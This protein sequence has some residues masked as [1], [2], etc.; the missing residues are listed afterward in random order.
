MFPP[1]TTAAS[2]VPSLEEVM[3][4][5]L[6]VAPADVSSVQV[7][8]ESVEVHMFPP[9]TTAASL[10]P[11]LEEVMPSQAFVVARGGPGCSRISGGPYVSVV[12][13]RGELGAVARGG[14]ATP[15]FRSCPRRS[16]CSRISGGPDVSVI[17]NRGEL[18][19]VARGGDA[20]PVL[21]SCPGDPV[22]PES[23]EVQMFPLLTVAASLVPSLEEVMQSQ[24][25]VAARD[26]QVAPESVE[27]Q[28]FPL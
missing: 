27:V 24:V 1:S 23:V 16:S 11:S 2:L 26:V 21:R 4:Y 22:A 13:N 12:D 25:C 10:V 5:Q 18:G 6:F 3:S 15:G 7:A 19:A 14:D 8:P 9:S 20:M 17:D 28:M